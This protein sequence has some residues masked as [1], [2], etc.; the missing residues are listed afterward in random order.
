MTGFFGFVSTSRTGAKSQLNPRARKLGAEGPGDP[1]G[2]G[3]VVQI[4]DAP[5]GRQGQHRRLQAG[6]PPPF[7]VH[8]DP[9]RRVRGSRRSEG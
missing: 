2:E 9:R 6:D 3:R 8:A 7:L 1:S 5:H 4:A